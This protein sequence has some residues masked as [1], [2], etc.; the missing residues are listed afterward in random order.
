[1]AC[2]PAIVGSGLGTSS[3][4]DRVIYNSRETFLSNFV[5]S[6]SEA[7]PRYGTQVL[8]P[9]ATNGTTHCEEEEE[10]NGRH[11]S[12]IAPTISSDTRRLLFDCFSNLSS[13]VL[14]IR[15]VSANVTYSFL[16][17]FL[18][19]PSLSLFSCLIPTPVP[20]TI[21]RRALSSARKGSLGGCAILASHFRGCGLPRVS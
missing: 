13:P 9:D 4:S 12:R 17:L 8:L 7:V 5:L 6:R 3:V 16:S 14:P 2:L 11:I 20:S 15:P 1:M 18:P 10:T 21:A 19:P